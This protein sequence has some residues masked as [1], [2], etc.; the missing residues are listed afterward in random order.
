[1]RLRNPSLPTSCKIAPILLVVVC[2]CRERKSQNTACYRQ[3]IPLARPIARCRSLGELI[4]RRQ[5]YVLFFQNGPTPLPQILFWP[6]PGCPEHNKTALRSTPQHCSMPGTRSSPKTI[7]DTIGNRS[8]LYGSIP[9]PVASNRSQ[10][11]TR[12]ITL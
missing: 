9:G 2:S 4:P 3:M 1:M 12:P 6:L 11:H 10:P 8:V 7:P 5:Q